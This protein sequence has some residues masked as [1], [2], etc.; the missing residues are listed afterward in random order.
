VSVLEGGY[1]I[2]SLRE[3]AVHHVQGLLQGGSM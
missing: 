2:E 3:C 1:Q